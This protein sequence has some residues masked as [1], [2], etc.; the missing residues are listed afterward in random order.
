MHLIQDGWCRNWRYSGSGHRDYRNR[1]YQFQI[2]LRRRF[3]TSQTSGRICVHCFWSSMIVFSFFPVPSEFHPKNSSFPGRIFLRFPN[4]LNGCSPVRN[5]MPPEVHCFDSWKP[6]LA[7]HPDDANRLLQRR[8]LYKS[9][10][11][12]SRTAMFQTSV[13]CPSFSFSLSLLLRLA[14]C[15]H[16][17]MKLMNSKTITESFPRFPF[18]KKAFAKK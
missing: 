5:L 1:K 3:I 13:I 18:Q 17:K 4:F 2:L 6:T 10:G 16:C 11:M 8:A 9:F 7:W 14:A 15:E 12:L